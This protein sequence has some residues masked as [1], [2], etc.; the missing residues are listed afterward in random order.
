MGDGVG[1]CVE[2]RRTGAQ[3]YLNCD[4]RFGAVINNDCITCLFVLRTGSMSGSV[5]VNV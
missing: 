2:D 5:A 1:L 3:A 4:D